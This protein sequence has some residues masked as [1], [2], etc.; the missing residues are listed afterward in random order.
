MPRHAEIEE[1][2]S[3]HV[4][5]TQYCL[6]IVKCTNIDC[7]LPFKSG[8]L[9]VLKNWFLPP[10]IP[11]TQTDT[12][13]KWV[14][15]ESGGAV[16]L[17]LHQNLAMQ[18]SL[19]PAS[20]RNKY[21]VEIPYNYSNPAVDSAMIEKRICKHCSRYFKVINIKTSHESACVAKKTK[22]LHQRIKK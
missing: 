6:Q 14:Q 4:R 21:P 18:D 1:W 7:C 19:K 10:P 12:G 22:H 15:N 11:I 3:I 13:L 8:Y 16:Y 2:Q 17:P 20:A 5:H 9:T